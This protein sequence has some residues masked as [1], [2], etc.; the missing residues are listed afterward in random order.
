MTTTMI[1]LTIPATTWDELCRLEPRLRDVDELIDLLTDPTDALAYYAVRNYASCLVGWARGGQASDE[2]PRTLIEEGWTTVA[3][4]DDEIVSEPRTDAE[5]WLRTSEAYDLA[6]D[7][8][9]D[10]LE[11]DR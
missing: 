5:R 6:L 3:D 1:R 2:A 10:R 4:L 9:I 7:H 8:L 11:Y